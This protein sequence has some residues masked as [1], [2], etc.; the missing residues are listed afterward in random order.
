VLA[1]YNTDGSFD[2]NFG[3][4]GFLITDFDDGTLNEANALAFQP[5]GK[6]VLAGYASEASGSYTDFALA[7]YSVAAPH[8][9][10]CDYDGDGK[11]DI[12]VWRPSEG[13]WYI[14]RSSTGTGMTQYLGGAGDIP[15]ASAYIP[16]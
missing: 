3:S 15:R 4:N 8:S 16:R 13:T 14:I 7:R 6:L 12:A 9:T 5:N 1:R 11:T 10:V 2:P